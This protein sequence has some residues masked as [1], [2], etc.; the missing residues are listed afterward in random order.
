MGGNRVCRRI[1]PGEKRPAR[2]QQRLVRLQHHGEFDQIVA[3]HP[4]QRSRAG[5]GSNR[6]AVNEG[7]AIFAQR[8][9]SITRRQ[10]QCLL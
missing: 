8:D 2:R 10:I 6:A 4:D 1:H 5:I 7:V 9:Q 3:A